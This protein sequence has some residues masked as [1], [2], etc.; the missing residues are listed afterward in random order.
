LQGSEAD[1]NESGLYSQTDFGVFC[2]DVPSFAITV[3]VFMGVWVGD[4]MSECVSE[5]G[6]YR[7]HYLVFSLCLIGNKWGV[8]NVL[9]LIKHTHTDLQ[10]SHITTYILRI[11]INIDYRALR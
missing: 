11:L 1:R 10:F 5:Y 3:L 2:M 9:K 4:V 7:M 8:I 6:Y